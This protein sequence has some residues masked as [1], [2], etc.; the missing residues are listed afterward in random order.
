MVK[1]GY[2]KQEPLKSLGRCRYL[3]NLE[4]PCLGNTSKSCYCVTHM[5]LNPPSKTLY[6]STN[7]AAKAWTPLH[8]DGGLRAVF[9]KSE[10]VR[11]LKNGV[12]S[13]VHL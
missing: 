11:I 12:I 2:S 9:S 1:H 6:I 8:P 13:I 5:T 10:R 3:K 7:R 4:M